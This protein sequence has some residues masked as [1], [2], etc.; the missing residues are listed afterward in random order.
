VIGSTI[1]A[2]MDI[3]APVLAGPELMYL[4]WPTLYA[5][6]RDFRKFDFLDVRHLLA[7]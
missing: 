4:C 3:D 5:H 2:T 6:D 1:L 7:A